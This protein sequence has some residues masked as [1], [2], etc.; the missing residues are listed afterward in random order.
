M[1]NWQHRE[2]P[3]PVF[4]M[5]TT[6]EGFRADALWVDENGVPRKN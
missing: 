1:E 6:E 2:A 5:M 3:E 4:S